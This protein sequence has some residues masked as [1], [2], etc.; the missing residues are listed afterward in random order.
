MKYRKQYYSLELN[1]SHYNK[2]SFGTIATW[3]EKTKEMDFKF[4]SKVPPLISH[5]SNFING[6]SSTLSFLEGIRTFKKTWVPFFYR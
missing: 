4:C 5:Y 6:G 1:A 3:A 2:Y